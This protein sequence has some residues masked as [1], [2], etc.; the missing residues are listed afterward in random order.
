MLDA[1]Q[2]ENEVLVKY[3]GTSKKVVVPEGVIAI[4][5]NAFSDCNTLRCVSFPTSLCTIGAFA[6]NNCTALEEVHAAS[7][8]HWLSLSFAGFRANPLSNGAKLFFGEEEITH[9]VVPQD[10]SCI[11]ARAFEGCSSLETVELSCATQTIGKLAF[12]SCAALK[13]VRVPNNTALASIEYGAFR[14]CAA[15]T[16]FMFPASLRCISSWA[17]AGC[18]ALTMAF[19]PDGLTTIERDAFY[20]C[21]A[22][23]FVRLPA[24]LQALTD[25]M[26]YGCSALETV[27]IPADVNAFGSNVFTRCEHIR[28]LWLEGASLPA[29]FVPPAALEVLVMPE[30]NF[31]ASCVRSSLL[32]PLAAGFVKLA[33]AGNKPLSSEGTQF[34]SLHLPD[35]LRALHYEPSVVAWLLDAGFVPQGQEANYAAQAAAFGQAEASALF[36]EQA[37]TGN[38]GC[39]TALDLEL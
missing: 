7:L 13:E 35:I 38:A 34:V 3:R 23:G 39:S 15:V 14:N 24:T 18:S 8:Q 6:F 28:E 31:D 20:G 27:H 16:S 19:L 25:D 9:V 5:E 37:H 10:V 2:I 22:L 32:L 21:T 36:L 17:F 26:F 4:R 11:G 29:G 30:G 12:G 33:A 1:M